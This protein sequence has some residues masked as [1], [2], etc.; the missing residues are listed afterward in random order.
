MCT[1]ASDAK[2]YLRSLDALA[3]IFCLVEDYPALERAASD[4][5]RLAASIPNENHAAYGRP[6]APCWPRRKTETGVSRMP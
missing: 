6:A 3:E 5:I 1:Q 4:A 2:L